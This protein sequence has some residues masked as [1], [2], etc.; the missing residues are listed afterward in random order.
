MNN[1]NIK[2]IL[3]FLV[4][5]VICGFIYW[6][7]ID[8]KFSLENKYYNNKGLVSVSG[9]NVDELVNSKKSF[10][11]FTYNN[12]CNFSIPCDEVFES[13]SKSSNVEILKI[14]F[15]DFKNTLLYEN[16]KYAPT[17]IIVN[18][19]RIIDYLDANAD[20]DIDLYQNEDK[21]KKW[22]SSYVNI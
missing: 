17:V 15:M 20:E 18:K 5:F 21:F 10:I 16:V 7:S 22:L 3:I 13:V 12:Y 6:F 1:N 19:G 4:L 14:N 2:Y 8:K 11:L 9:D